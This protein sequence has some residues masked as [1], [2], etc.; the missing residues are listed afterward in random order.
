MIASLSQHLML[1]KV[2]GDNTVDG[3]TVPVGGD[4]LSVTMMNMVAIMWLNKIQGGNKEMK[5]RRC[6]TQENQN[7]TSELRVTA[8]KRS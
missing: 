2:G 1:H 4:T 3:T 7:L 6:K 8:P 5:K